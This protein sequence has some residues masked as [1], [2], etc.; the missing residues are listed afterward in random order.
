MLYKEL[1]MLKDVLGG[2]LLLEEN[3]ATSRAD[4]DPLQVLYSLY[5]L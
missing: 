3:A 1:F 5:I 2:A 4:Q